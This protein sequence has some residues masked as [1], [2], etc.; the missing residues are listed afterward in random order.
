MARRMTTTSYA[1]L[2]LLDLQP[3]TGYS[4]TQQAARSLHFAW[5]KSERQLYSEPKKLVELGYAT[6]YKEQ[7]GNRTRNVYEITEAG[8]QA[9]TDWAATPPAPPQLEAEALL[10]LLFADQGTLDDL[11][12]SLDQ[13]RADTQEL[14]DSVQDVIGGYPNDQHPFPQRTHLSVLF[15]TFQTELFD[16]IKR[17]TDFAQAEIDHW[18]STKDLGMTERTEEL[19]HAITTSTPLLDPP[20]TTPAEPRDNRR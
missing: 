14:H 10:R 19:I 13:L 17:W 9:L 16:L 7:I 20:Q 15:A 6:T 4:L 18:P 1:I 2:A 12:A 8:R 11:N 3:W 5:P